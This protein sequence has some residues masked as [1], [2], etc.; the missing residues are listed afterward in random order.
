MHHVI[1]NTQHHHAEH[2]SLVAEVAVSSDEKLNL[3]LS[4]QQ[5]NRREMQ[6]CIDC[7]FWLG[8]EMAIINGELY[9]NYK[10]LNISL[11]THQSGRYNEIVERTLLLDLIVTSVDLPLKLYYELN[12][13]VKASMSEYDKIVRQ[14]DKS[15]DIEKPRVLTGVFTRKSEPPKKRGFLSLINR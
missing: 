11:Q 10:G 8:L 5:P 2:I 15:N 6:I 12:E 14:F 3:L 4:C 7:H 9:R 1:L 13:M